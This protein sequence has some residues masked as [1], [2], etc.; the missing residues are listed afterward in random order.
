MIPQALPDDGKGRTGTNSKRS[1]PY[2]RLLADADLEKFSA[3]V[4]IGAREFARG[5]VFDTRVYRPLSDVQP[6]QPGD[7]TAPN[8]QHMPVIRDFL[9]PVD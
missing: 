3:P 2:D 8:M 9:V 5:L 6:A 1:K 7:S 4:R